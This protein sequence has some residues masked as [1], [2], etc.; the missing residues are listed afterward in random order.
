MAQTFAFTYAARPGLNEDAI[1]RKDVAP[2]VKDVPNNV[3][4]VCHYGFSEMV[5]NVIDHSGT[6]RF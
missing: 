4:R 5:N 1:W 6:E 2:L 3:E